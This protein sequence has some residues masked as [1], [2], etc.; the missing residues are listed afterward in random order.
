MARF[1]I[2]CITSHKEM[3]NMHAEMSQKEAEEIKATRKAA[4]EA[5]RAAKAAQALAK[6]QVIYLFL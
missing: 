4:Q 6:R 3:R 1:F 5:D 2:Y